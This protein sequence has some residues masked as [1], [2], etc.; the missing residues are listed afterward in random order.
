M[1]YDDFKQFFLNKKYAKHFY[2][3]FFLKTSTNE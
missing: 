2:E 3:R 1:K